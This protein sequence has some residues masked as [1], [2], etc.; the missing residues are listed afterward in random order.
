MNSQNPNWNQNWKH[1]VGINNQ[2]MGMAPQ[3]QPT[4]QASLQLSQNPQSQ[5]FP[6]LPSQPHPNPNNR[7][8]QLIQIM[9]NGEG[10]INFV[11]CNKLRLRSGRII[12][13]EEN[14]VFQ[15]QEKQPTIT[16][17]TVEIKEEIEQGGGDIVKSQYPDK[18]V[19][20]SL[21]F[22]ERFMIEKPTVYPNFDLV[23][24]LKFIYQDS[25]PTSSS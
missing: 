16:P 21:P 18:G 9:E 3:T 15:E 1:A 12:S 25:T 20:P 13:P 7:L 23:G 10:E 17:P 8:D 4:L 22:H 24:E 2:P 6:Q 11:G 19:T 5:L 14:D